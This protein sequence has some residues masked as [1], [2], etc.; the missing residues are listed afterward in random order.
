MAA[1]RTS[2]ILISLEVIQGLDKESVINKC[3]LEALTKKR[4]A[5]E[6]QDIALFGVEDATKMKEQREA[7]CQYERNYFLAVAKPFLQNHS[8]L[9]TVYDIEE[10]HERIIFL[11]IQRLDLPTINQ[12]R[13][14]ELEKWN[15]K[16]IEFHNLTIPHVEKI[17]DDNPIELTRDMIHLRRMNVDIIEKIYELIQNGKSNPHALEHTHHLNY[18]VHIVFSKIFKLADLRMRYFTE[19]SHEYVPLIHKLTEEQ[20]KHLKYTFISDFFRA[21]ALLEN[22][23]LP[24]S[25]YDDEAVLLTCVGTIIAKTINKEEKSDSNLGPLFKMFLDECVSGIESNTSFTEI[26]QCFIL[27]TR[28]YD[29]ENLILLCTKAINMRFIKVLEHLEISLINILHAI[30]MHCIIKHFGVVSVD[31]L[32]ISLAKAKS[33]FQEIKESIWVQH[34]LKDDYRSKYTVE[35][36]QVGVKKNPQISGNLDIQEIK[37]VDDRFQA[38]IYRIF[39]QTFHLQSNLF[40]VLA[41]ILSIVINLEIAKHQ[42]SNQEFESRRQ[43][44]IDEAKTELAD[45]ETNKKIFEMVKSK[46]L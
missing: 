26:T 28:R 41:E 24:T 7:L 19:N 44:L 27:K 3:R 43:H 10:E 33:K 36:H 32:N 31:E 30:Y 46:R 42:L 14:L 17:M 23:L 18:I 29:W 21:Q 39:L 40:S 34:K 4:I 1:P 2:E 5:L 12:K 45:A 37:A 25:R 35:L 13:L 38:K 8:Y 6:N 16:K 15:Q 11:H 22:K 9:N 20:Q